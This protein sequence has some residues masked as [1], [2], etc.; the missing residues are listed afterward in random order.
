M[1]CREIMT[2]CPGKPLFKQSLIQL[3]LYTSYSKNEA[4]SAVHFLY[5]QTKQLLIKAESNDC[6]VSTDKNCAHENLPAWQR[7]YS[8]HCNYLTNTLLYDNF[9]IWSLQSVRLVHSV[10]PL[11]QTCLN[12][13]QPLNSLTDSSLLLSHEAV[14][15]LDK[16][17]LEIM[18]VKG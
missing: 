17:L 10:L 7:G 12:E 9:Y 11:V 1:S 18:F 3:F 13:P 5:S 6:F 2:S 15:I 16:K 4:C 8:R 14:M